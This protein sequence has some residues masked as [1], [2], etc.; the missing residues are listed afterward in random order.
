VALGGKYPAAQCICLLGK[1]LNIGEW[2]TCAGV[3]NIASVASK[4]VKNHF[5]ELLDRIIGCILPFLL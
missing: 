2:I 5:L 4:P 3:T 1:A